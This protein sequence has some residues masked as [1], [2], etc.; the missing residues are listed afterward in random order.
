MRR[1]APPY[2]ALVVGALASTLMCGTALGAQPPGIPY[3]SPATVPAASQ[4]IAGALINGNVVWLDAS[5]LHQLTS[6]GTILT[7]APTSS[8][9]VV[10]NP[11]TSGVLINDATSQP[12]SNN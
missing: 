2:R 3:A 5:G 6:S 4:G 10:I 12:V 11:A 1:H 7:F 9:N 8:A